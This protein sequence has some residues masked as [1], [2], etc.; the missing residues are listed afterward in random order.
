MAMASLLEEEHGASDKDF[1]SDD[2]INEDDNVECSEHDT[3]SEEDAS[4]LEKEEEEPNSLSV[5]DGTSSSEIGR[6]IP[7][8]TGNSEGDPEQP[9]Y[10]YGKNKCITWCSA[11]PKSSKVSAKNIMKVKLPA[12]Q[13]KAKTLGKNPNIDEVWRL[14]FDEDLIQEI[15]T[16]TNKKMKTMRDKLKDQQSS[17]YR[18][19]DVIE[20]EALIGL[21]ML[22]AIF[23]SGKEDLSSLFSTGPFGRPI[24]R[25]VMS[26]KRCLTLLLALRFDDA[27]T[28]KKR[29]LTD[30][31]AAI[32]HL[33]YKF[34]KNCQD[35]FNIGN[36]ACI[37]E[38]LVPFR[39]RCPFRIY[40]PNKPAKYG[41]KVLCLTD[42]HTSYLYNAYLYLGKDSD[43]FTLSPE[44]RKLSKPTQSVIRLCKPIANS[45]RNVTADNWFSSLE[46][47]RELKK[48]KLTYVGTM[49]SNKKE[50]PP[51]FHAEKKRKVGS[52]VYGFT[53]DVT[54]VSYVPKPN[55]AVNLLSS[56]HDSKF[57]DQS[58]NKPE[59][60]SFYNAT[61]SGVDNLDKIIAI[62]SPNRRSRRW[63][64]TVFYNMIAV[65]LVNSGIIY[66]S[67]EETPMMKRFDFIHS[68]ANI[69]IKKQVER[70]LT[71]PN[72]PNC[73]KKI[74]K[75]IL[76][77]EEQA[78]PVTK[79]ISDRLPKRKTCRYCAYEKRRQTAYKCIKCDNPCCLE[80]S[81]KKKNVI[82]V[83]QQLC[84]VHVGNNISF[85]L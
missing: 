12:L 33:F 79:D 63:P 68:L 35:A 34:I 78:S 20:L 49:R 6:R 27:N 23:K 50:I 30:P 69:L 9:E 21:M 76:N 7:D 82:S 42:A 75:D 3:D 77:E 83:L 53:S 72:L 22:C 40:M 64:L 57:T 73:L 25:G 71:I 58:N 56:M 13:P 74:I 46:V 60:I 16:C 43:G 59:V 5:K 38:M 61:K 54:L 80:C 84:K 11:E 28:R 65:S 18:D 70:R 55:K 47:V 19:T 36:H 48:I 17:N 32:S 66:A 67:F 51:E 10:F 1:D 14:L 52:S 24:F 39:G 26:L 41:L 37:D 2:S 81:K 15:V 8:D 29:T 85:T 4:F 31:A 62:Y 45:N 44:E